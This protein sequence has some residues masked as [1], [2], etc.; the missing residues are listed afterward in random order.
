MSDRTSPSPGRSGGWFADRPLPVKFGALVGS[1]LAGNG[2]VRE[3]DEETMA[4]AHAEALVLQLDTRASELKVDA[5]R[6]LVREVPAEALAEVAEDAAT[7][8]ELLTEL[9][10][11]ALT[12]E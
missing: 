12:G 8:D 11:I 5:F 2:T 1:V 7:A 9:S 10:G 3:A 4:L 6:A